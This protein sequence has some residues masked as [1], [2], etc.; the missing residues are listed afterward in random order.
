MT[1]ELRFPTVP[2]SPGGEDGPSIVTLIEVCRSFLALDLIEICDA[3]LGPCGA[4]S[5]KGK[6][7]R[8]RSRNRDKG[9]GRDKQSDPSLSP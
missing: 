5:R 9:K 1:G 8:S 3:A 6:R 4:R 7:S 2:C